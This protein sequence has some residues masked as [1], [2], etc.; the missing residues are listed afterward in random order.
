MKNKSVL[1]GIIIVVIVVLATGCGFYNLVDAEEFENHFGALGYTISD[2]EEPKY[3]TDTYL[4]ATKE[5]MPFKI[6]YYEF[7]EEIEAKKVYEKYKDSIADY[8]TSDSS[9]K[10]TTGAVFAKTVAVSEKE[11]LIISRVKNTIIFIAGT[12][13]YSNEIDKLVEEIEY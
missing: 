1:L 4:V 3:E 5:D 12:N 9:N 7:N 13:D 2:S 6:E 11:Y 10:E 8:I